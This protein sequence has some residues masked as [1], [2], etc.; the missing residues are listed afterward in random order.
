MDP[1][2][3]NDYGW[4][5]QEALQHLQSPGDEQHETNGPHARRDRASQDN[6]VGGLGGG[7][8]RALWLT[9][10]W[11]VWRRNR[12][13]PRHDAGCRRHRRHHHVVV[14]SRRRPVGVQRG[15]VRR[16]S[17]VRQRVVRRGVRSGADAVQRPAAAG[18]QHERPVAGQR[19][20]VRREPDVRRGSGV[21][22]G[23]NGVVWR[24]LQPGGTDVRRIAAADVRG[25][26]VARH[27]AGMLG[28]HPGV[29]PGRVR[30]VHTEVARV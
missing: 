3:P 4:V 19:A 11:R 25:R 14:P 29:L 24:K 16:K 5:A 13:R 8:G 23:R 26:Y 27:R 12:R 1:E 6:R 22:R 30:A 21:G 9:R 7:L 17:H 28:E 2:G 20:D 15:V 18:V 10:R